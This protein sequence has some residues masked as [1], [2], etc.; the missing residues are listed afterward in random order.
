MHRPLSQRSPPFGSGYARFGSI[1][2]ANVVFRLED[3]AR[4]L[5][6]DVVASGEFVAGLG[7]WRKATVARSAS[8]KPK[9]AP[10][11]SM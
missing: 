6:V 7:R 9:G 3:L 10:R 4:K 11:W 8:T 2:C 1:V 5:G